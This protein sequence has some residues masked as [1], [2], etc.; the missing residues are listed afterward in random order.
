[1][2]ARLP[3]RAVGALDEAL[4]ADGEARRA[5]RNFLGMRD[6]GPSLHAT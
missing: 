5:A 6:D 4:A 2:L 3:A 1:V